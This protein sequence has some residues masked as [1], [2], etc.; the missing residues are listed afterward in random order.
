VGEPANRASRF[1]DGAR[2]GEVIVSPEIHERV[3]LVVHSKPASV[4]T[5]HEGELRGFRVT[6]MKA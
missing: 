1:C 4:Q 6:A 3:F 5:K 2:A